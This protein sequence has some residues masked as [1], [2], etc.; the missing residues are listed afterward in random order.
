MDEEKIPDAQEQRFRAQVRLIKRLILGFV[1]GG[2][3]ALLVLLCV[4][5]AYSIHQNAR[6]G[7]LQNE[8]E[9]LQNNTPTAKEEEQQPVQ[10]PSFSYQQAYPDLY[11]QANEQTVPH[12]GTVYLTFDDGP[13]PT[14]LEL[15]DVLDTFNVKASFFL[16]GT[17]VDQYPEVVQEIARRG[18]T[19]GIH[20]NDHTYATL[21]QSVDSFL[22][23]YETVSRKLEF[24][25]GKKPDIFRFPGGSINSYNRDLYMQLIAEMIRRGYVY[26]DWNVS[27][28]DA[29]ARQ[30]T[31]ESIE[32]DVREQIG[33]HS[34]SIVLMHDS[35]GKETTV[36]ALRE[37]IPELQ[38]QGYT[39]AALDNSVE[40]IVFSY[41]NN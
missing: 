1:I 37:L 12:E 32:K 40:P 8:L 22:L 31:S 7:Y 33:N 18:H 21:Y 16:V 11:V 30:R 36:D 38:Q 20:A 27:A 14:T 19:I 5:G 29:V 13:S 10:Q 3:G 9:Q 34:Y 39:F 28:E 15:L 41:S 6:I 26:Y 24:L 25:T 4:L 35:A 17:A 23:D 2:W